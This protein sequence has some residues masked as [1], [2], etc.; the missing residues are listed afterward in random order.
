[1]LSLTLTPKGKYF[2][3]RKRSLLMSAMILRASN[4]SLRGCY[5]DATEIA[6][7]ILPEPAIYNSL[8]CKGLHNRD[9][10]IRTRDPLNPI[11]VRYRTALRPA[12]TFI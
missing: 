3:A 2:L 4:L 12:A 8:Y 6:G 7:S 5:W 9:G 1:M 10:G 11:Q